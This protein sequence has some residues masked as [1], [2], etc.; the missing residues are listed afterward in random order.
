MGLQKAFPVLLLLV[1]LTAGAAPSIYLGPDATPLEQC[2]ATELQRYLYAV[3]DKLTGIETVDSVPLDATGFVLGTPAS[4]PDVGAAWPFGLEPPEVDGYVLHSLAE[5]DR[6]LIVIAAPIPAGVQNG[7]YGLLEDWGFGFYLGGD[8]FPDSIPTVAEA[9]E[10]GLSVSKTPVF[11]VRGSLPWYNFFNSPTAWELADHKAFI[12]QLVKMR[13]NFLGFHAY[14]SEPFAAY[15]H[16]GRLVGGGPLVNTSK[17]TWGTHPMATDDFLGGTGRYFAREHFGAASSSVEDREAS[18]RAAKDVLR[19]ALAYAKSRGMKVCLGFEVRGDALEVGVQAHFEAR[20]KALLADYPMLDYVWLWEPEGM[21]ASPGPGPAPRTAW[22]SYTDRWAEAFSDVAEPAR[23]AEAVRLSLFALHARQV[24]QALRPDV[25]IVVS[26]WGGDQWLHCSDFYAGMDKILPG[27]IAFSALD[28]IRVTPTVSEAYG[29]VSPDRQRW[30]IVWFEFDGD[31]WMPQ[32][33]LNEIAGACRDALEKGCQGLLGIH[34]RTRAVEEA[35]GY[36][37]RFAWDPDLSVEDFCARRARDLFG[38]DHA[39][40]MAGLLLRLQELGY[41]WVGG[42]GQA[43]C[44]AFNW[45]AG[46][47]EKQNELVTIA[48]ELRALMSEGGLLPDG[49]FSTDLLKDIR[50]TSGGLSKSIEGFS[51]SVLREIQSLDIGLFGSLLM[52][53]TGIQTQTP[54]EDLN[55]HIAYVLGYDRAAAMLAPGAGLDQLFEEGQAVDAAKLI[56][57]SKLAEA[58]HSYALRINNKGELGVLATINAK[59]WA[60]ILERTEFDEETLA[61]LKSV[62]EVYEG[63][64]GLLVLP[65]RVIVVGVPEERLH[66]TLRARP[67]GAKRFKKYDL[68]KMGRTTFALEFP[69]EVTETTNFEYGIEVKGAKQTRLYWPPGF[70]AEACTASALETRT[71]EAPPAPGAPDVTPVSV[72]HTVVP[73]QYSVQL[74]WAPRP[75]ETYAV[76]R[77]G[78]VLATV[79]DGWWE[80]RAPRT[81]TRLTYTVT[82]R[83]LASGKT[84]ASDVSVA[85]PE[86]PLPHPP[87]EIRMT[88]RANRVILGWECDAPAAA[89]YAVTRFDE[90][91]EVVG[92]TFVDADYMHYLQVSDP[93][94]GGKAYTYTIA[95]VT[96]DGR[97]G[98]PSKKTG[99]IASDEPVR[100]I[101]ELSFQDETFLEGLAEVA[102]QAL[103]LGGEGWAELPPQ[104]EWNLEHELTLNVWVKLD[105]LG[106]MPVLICKGAWQQAGYFLQILNRQVRFFVAGVDTLDAGSPVTG[107]WQHIVATYG[108]GEMSIYIDGQLVGR[109]RVTGRPRPSADPLLVGRYGHSDEVYFVHGLMDDVRIYDVALTPGEVEALY[110]GAKRE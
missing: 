59:A 94:E 104:S 106:G 83:N 95:G 89:R 43:E 91:H 50:D 16:E 9:V 53:K 22:E 57:E 103:A 110:Q 75:G 35:A 21:G 102:D 38:E 68:L 33:N 100:P 2:A 74:D 48:Y 105:D 80:D 24:V 34:W 84:A 3:T 32:P 30:P 25:G 4:L 88:S 69:Q 64:P 92:E 15:E 37:A 90:N 39:D 42:A 47:A 65:D 12:D 66:V 99:I 31:Q 70:P 86:F 109:K 44:G 78:R 23:R 56:R 76:S 61:S 17:A 18:I 13:C 10:E 58:M 51:K 6:A 55:A 77:D 107:R 97:I 36:C 72:T 14:D 20:L 26:G 93:V 96:P 40:A 98:P 82:A 87:K 8:T 41:R 49:L 81:G 62:P 45:S 108:Y 60:D 27:D 54:F 19:Q 1:S 5:G 71:F 85:V 29:A 73:D 67:L 7:V 11:T 101:L 28:N 52:K 46:E 79:C 63:R